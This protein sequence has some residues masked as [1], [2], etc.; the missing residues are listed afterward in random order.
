MIQ[1]LFHI[2]RLLLQ[3][4][5]LFLL[6]ATCI[7]LV[8]YSNSTSTSFLQRATYWGFLTI[9]ISIVLII[10]SLF[11]GSIPDCIFYIVSL[12]IATIPLFVIIYTR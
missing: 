11:V 2:I 8:R 6:I 3:L 5:H 12:L 4:V 7:Y 9:L 10:V 1:D